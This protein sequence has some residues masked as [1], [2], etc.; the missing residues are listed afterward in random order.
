M[1]DAL[2]N[3]GW[4]IGLAFQ[5][6]D[7]YLD[8]FGKE[9]GKERGKD[10]REHK[11]GNVAIIHALNEL[12][13][14]GKRAL[15]KILSRRRVSTPDLEKALILIERTGSR[16]KTLGLAKKF[17]EEGKASL[18]PLLESDAKNKLKTIADFIYTRLY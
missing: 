2:E 13:E 14:G 12:D 1:L 15:T 9:T 17:V 11:L 16:E 8:I 10:I 7:D 3:F 6:M 18:G 4:K 5:V